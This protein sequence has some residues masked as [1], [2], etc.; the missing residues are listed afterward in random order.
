MAPSQKQKKKKTET[1]Q[2]KFKGLRP[3]VTSVVF[4]S[5]SYRVRKNKQTKK[6]TQTRV[7]SSY[8]AIS[9]SAPLRGG[10]ERQEVPSPLL[11]SQ[12]REQGLS[13]KEKVKQGHGEAHPGRQVLSVVPEQLQEDKR[14]RGR[15]AGEEEWPQSQPTVSV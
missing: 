9:K 15:D 8:S 7:P 3:A 1:E 13:W 2:K 4:I 12:L 5:S 6:K 10:R 14:E 11:S